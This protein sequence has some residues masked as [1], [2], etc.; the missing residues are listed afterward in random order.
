MSYENLN[1]PAIDAMETEKFSELLLNPIDDFIAL[2]Q[3]DR[4]WTIFE[5]LRRLFIGEVEGYQACDTE[6]HDLE[7]T[8]ECAIAMS[9]LIAGMKRT[10]VE[11]LN[12]N[13]AELGLVAVLF[14]DTGYIK[15]KEDKMGTGAKYTKI[16][17]NRSVAFVAGHISPFGYTGEEIR[18]IQNMIRCTGLNVDLSKITFQSDEERVMGY[19]LGTA[20]LLGQMASPRYLEK[21]PILFLEF[22]EG[23]IEDFQDVED[24]IRKTPAFFR[25][26]VCK[27]F[28]ED[29]EGVYRYISHFFP[30]GRNHYML[31]IENNIKKIEYIIERASI[32][33]KR[34]G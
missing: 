34:K 20:D 19:C 2:E 23:G 24:L 7:H 29:F 10:G 11:Y 9:R 15:T 31:A 26:F 13:I 8:M 33:H 30:D 32:L 12:P 18:A 14:H 28:E 5:Y 3:K 1:I 22:L 25:V 17:V 21:L 4:I 16:H 6:Y 27:R